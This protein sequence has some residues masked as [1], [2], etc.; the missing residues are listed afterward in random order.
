MDIY[1]NEKMSIFEY[2]YLGVYDQLFID[3]YAFV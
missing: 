3:V 2:L 1:F